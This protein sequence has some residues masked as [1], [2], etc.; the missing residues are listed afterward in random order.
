MPSNAL[1]GTLSL[2]VAAALEHHRARPRSSRKR[3]TS[4]LLPSPDGPSTNTHAAAR[5]DSPSADFSS[6]SSVARPTNTSPAIRGA[7]RRTGASPA[8]AIASTSRPPARSPGLGASRREHSSDKSAGTPCATR[9]GA[10]GCTRLAAISSPTVLP[11]YGHCPVSEWNS[12]TPTA[13]Q[14]AA[15][16][17]TAPGSPCSGAMNTGVPAMTRVDATSSRSDRSATSPKSMI[18]TRP[19]GVTRMLPG[20]MSRWTLPLACSA[21]SPLATCASASRR[22]TSSNARTPGGGAAIASGPSGDATPTHVPDSLGFGT[23]I[24]STAGSGVP[25]ASAGSGASPRTQVAKSQPST[26]SIVKNHVPSNSNSS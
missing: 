14:S 19:A 18:T 9:A 1:Y 2:G 16:P 5:R 22:R 20:L 21:A 6:A 25:A 8:C 3:R 23:G 7:L 4:A 15:G 12:I 24:A 10:R 11:L 17:T 26:S 13:Y